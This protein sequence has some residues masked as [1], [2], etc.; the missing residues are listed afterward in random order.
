MLQAS[1][2]TKQEACCLL[3]L[4]TH[5]PCVLQTSSRHVSLPVAVSVVTTPSAS[6]SLGRM[7]LRGPSAPGDQN[8]ITR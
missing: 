2:G 8:L 5:H 4:T 1:Q 7:I 6:I 3:G